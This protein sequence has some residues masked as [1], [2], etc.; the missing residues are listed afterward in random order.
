LEALSRQGSDAGGGKV[1]F[2]LGA[3]TFLLVRLD[4]LDGDASAEGRQGGFNRARR[5]V[6]PDAAATLMA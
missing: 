3:E 4:R 1:G 5:F 2:G 6:A